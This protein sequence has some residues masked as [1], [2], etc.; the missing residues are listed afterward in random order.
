VAGAGIAREPSL[1]GERQSVAGPNSVGDPGRRD[2]S[3]AAPNDHLAVLIVATTG[4]TSEQGF[5]GLSGS[6]G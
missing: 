2:I 3:A 1:G 5:F 4:Q 6:R